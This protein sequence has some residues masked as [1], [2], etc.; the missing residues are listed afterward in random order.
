MNA[1]MDEAQYV[2]L[3]WP[4]I[5]TGEVDGELNWFSGVMALNISYE[6]WQQ[7]NEAK[8]RENMSTIYTHE[9]FHFLQ[10]STM[11]FVHDWAA[12]LFHVLRPIIKRVGSS[13]FSSL[14][15]IIKEGPALLSSQER[16]TLDQHFLKFDRRDVSGLTARMIFESQ[17]YFVER[18][19]NYNIDNPSD[20]TPHLIAVP[21]DIY[22]V[23]FDFLAY[24]AG[25]SVA[26]EWFSSVA[27]VSLCSQNPAMSFTQLS[28]ALGRDKSI[29]SM[30]RDPENIPQM[31]DYLIQQ[32]PDVK[33]TNP[34]ESTYR[35]HPIFSTAAKEFRKLASKDLFN[36]NQ[37]F[38]RPDLE[39]RTIFELN[40]IEVPIIFK[41]EPPSR[42][43]IQ[44]PT[45]LDEGGVLA[46]FSI[47]AIGN[48]LTRASA[49]SSDIESRKSLEQLSWLVNDHQPVILQLAVEDLRLGDPARMVQ[50]FN[51]AEE[52]K[53]L[54]KLWGRVI[55]Q[56]PTDID[57]NQDLHLP[58][59]P[60]A[61]QLLQA[62]HEK[63]PMFPVYLYPLFGI[64]D[65]FGAIGPEEALIDTNLNLQH[66]EI[67]KLL[68]KIALTIFKSGEMMGLNPWLAI[69]CLLGFVDIST[70]PD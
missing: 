35:S 31:I 21:D 34:L 13:D 49:T 5:P 3:L 27:S 29:A 7:F 68:H 18:T 69:K 53:T 30:T 56:L 2:E 32:L 65:W 47:G 50:L 16:A 40:D 19:V 4:I 70:K 38:G 55:L 60:E 14:K 33:L 57:P 37:L 44:R 63:L 39:L 15:R 25:Y 42:L 45:N 58:C 52:P 46:L 10:F 12:D 20:W 51:P 23:A 1:P 17:A 36:Q 41:P 8:D 48:Q 43:V 67:E 61:R 26:F 59:I 62:I 54:S 22:R 64:Y 11:G 9:F 66:P 24:G 28:L 6:S